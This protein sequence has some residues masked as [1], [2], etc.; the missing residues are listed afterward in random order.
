MA[1]PKKILLIDDNLEFLSSAK[2]FLMTNT[3]NEFSVIDSTTNALEGIALIEAYQPDFVLL[4]LSMPNLNGWDIIEMTR[5]L[6]HPPAI[7]ILTVSDNQMYREKAK[8]MGAAG[9]VSK[10]DFGEKLIPALRDCNRYRHNASS[11]TESS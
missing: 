5:F 6:S 3:D 9:F 10:A 11:N 1:A 8:R 7:I 4:D 2:E